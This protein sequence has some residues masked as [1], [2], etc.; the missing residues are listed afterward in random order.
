MGMTTNIP[1]I[2]FL[3]TGLYVPP[4][5]AILTGAQQDI[6]A[7]FGVT[8]NPNEN[9]PQGQLADAYSAAVAACYAVF[10]QIVNMI[11]PDVA[12]GFFQDAILRIYYL[13]RIQGEPT[14]VE[15]TCTGAVGTVINQ[16][17]LAQDTSGNL[18]AALSAGTIGSSGTVSLTFQNLVDGPTPCPAATLT[19]I[20][21]QVP[22]WESITNP[23]DGVVGS[24]V[25]SAAAA[26]YRRQQSVAGNA[27][28]FLGAVYGAVFNV[29]DVIDVFCVE[30]DTSGTVLYGA[31][32]Y[33]LLPNSIY[34]GVIG[35]D[36]TA[37]AEAVWSKK[38]PG[39][40]YNGNTTVDVTDTS[41]NY[42]NPPVYAVKYNN[43]SENPV[44]VYFSVQIQSLS[45]LPANIVSLVQTAIVNQFT[46][47]AGSPRA[48]IGSTLVAGTFTAAVQ[49]CAGA[50]IV[51]PVLSVSIGTAFTGAATLV[52]DSTT[53]TVTTASTGLLTFGTA[54]S[55]TGIASGAY[56]QQQLTGTPGG[57]GTYQMSLPANATVSSPE[58]IVGA[59]NA[60]AT[61]GIDQ[62]PTISA[63]NVTVSLVS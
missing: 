28:G 46:G 19:V 11:N 47:A 55:G 25:E 21:Q 7:A 27:Q 44:E 48:R 17:A 59:L 37:I 58:S 20:Y 45:T 18:Y 2:Q 54:L 13:S 30:N 10:A 5:S 60:F 38:S 53:L 26:E 8:L 9:T 34:V 29:P 62:A 42:Q 56:I 4:E 40:N 35:G 22:G 50:N 14:T 36:S 15:C 16:G 24:Y 23:A 33:S 49:T 32:N 61:F 41:G 43:N 39:C 31:T 57:V 1:P 63:S 12:T 52:D 3:S 6:N 51:V